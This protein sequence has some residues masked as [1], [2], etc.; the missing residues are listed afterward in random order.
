MRR[1]SKIAG[2]GETFRAKLTLQSRQRFFARARQHDGRTLRMQAARDGAADAAG[3]AG[4]QRRLAA[5]IEHFISLIFVA[6][7][8]GSL[9]RPGVPCT[10]I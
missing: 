9:A 2:G 8:H 7:F 6:P 10:P 4:D 3:G 5:E 1:Y